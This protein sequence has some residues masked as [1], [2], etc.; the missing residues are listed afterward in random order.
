MAY[1]KMAENILSRIKAPALHRIDVSLI[2]KTTVNAFIGREAHL[3]FL[4]NE[5]LLKMILYRYAHLFE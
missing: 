5:V 1:V 3:Q 2:S 4:E